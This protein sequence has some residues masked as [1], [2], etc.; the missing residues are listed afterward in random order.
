[1]DPR[2]EYLQKILDLNQR[3]VLKCLDG[4]SDAHFAAPRD[5][6]N[7]MQWI[8]GH[9]T[10][11]RVLMA[12]MLG[13]SLEFPY[14]DQFKRGATRGVPDQLP[15]M[16]EIVPRWNEACGAVSVGLATAPSEVFGRAVAAE[17]PPSADGTV[18]GCIAFMTMHDSYHLGQLGWLRKAFGYPTLAG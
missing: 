18:L 7:S 9:L 16:V 11:S 10:G 8:F 1:M 3:L 12:R 4:V 2:A 17:G 14:R 6:G 15:A 5:G 13:T